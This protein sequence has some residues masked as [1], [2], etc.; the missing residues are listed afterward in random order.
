VDDIVSNKEKKPPLESYKEKKAESLKV[1]ELYNYDFNKQ[2]KIKYCAVSLWRQ[3]WEH[4]ETK[5][6]KERFTSRN[7]QLRFCPVCSWRKSL[8]T[9][10]IIYS[11]LSK[12]DKYDYLFLTLTLKNCKIMDLKDTL[13]LMSESF[14]RMKKIP[15]WQNSIRGYVRSLEIT[16]SNDKTMHPHYHVLLQVIPSYLKHKKTYITQQIF[17]DLWKNALKIDYKPIVDV[18]LIRPK[19]EGNNSLIASVAETVKYAL[20][21]SDLLK[22]NRHSFPILDEAMKGVKTIN[23]GG[24][25]LHVQKI[26]K[27]DDIKMTDWRLLAEELFKW[28][29][30]EYVLQPIIEES[31][32][33]EFNFDDE[34]FINPAFEMDDYSMGFVL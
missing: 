27:D 2:L 8:K 15:Q 30:G 14:A 11:N 22:L 32:Q 19:G 29:C 4:I 33:P 28:E 16:V 34:Y 26:S 6:L 24:S 9:S 13:K 20:K 18:R 5:D 25:L 17:T 10:S 31:N 12:L 3:T 23:C 7:C 1:L 21:S